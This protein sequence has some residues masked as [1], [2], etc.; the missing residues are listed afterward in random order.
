YVGAVAADLRS[1]SP[2]ERPDRTRHDPAPVQIA[3]AVDVPAPDDAEA[4]AVGR[5]VALGDEIAGRLRDVVRRRRAKRVV[6]DVGAIAL[7]VG[8]VARCHH[9]TLDRSRLAA[10]R[11]KHVVG[12]AD[13]GLERKQ[14][15][16]ERDP[17][18]RLRTKV[19]YD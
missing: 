8:L 6:L 14:R 11:L 18:E 9:E 15:S 3:T 19:E 17:D 5:V 4:Q 1:L 12:P 13:V 16:V 2:Q 10:A 7:A